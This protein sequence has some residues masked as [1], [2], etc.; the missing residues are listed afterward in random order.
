MARAVLE[1]VAYNLKAILDV[2]DDPT[3]YPK[4]DDITFIGGGAKSKVWA[5]IMAD[6][7]GIPVV[8]PRYLEEATSMGAAV[9]GGVGVGAFPDFK[10]INKFNPEE[11]KIYPRAEH[12]ERYDEMYRIFNQTYEALKPVYAALAPLG[13]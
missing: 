13:K 7:W 12:R 6:I 9:C 5:Q 2:F 11:R 3:L 8:I 1:G 4:F 10:V